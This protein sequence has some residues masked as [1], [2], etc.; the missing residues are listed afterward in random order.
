MNTGKVRASNFELLRIFSMF[1]IVLNHLCQHGIWFR[2]DAEIT[3]NLCISNCLL[4]WTGTLGNWLFVLT[5]GYFVSKSEFSWKKV[6]KLW[7]Q[8]FFYSVIIGVILYLSQT[9]LIG[10]YNEDYIELGF[11]EA[12]KPA[13]LIDLAQSFAPTLFGN[14]WFASSY[15]LFYCFTPFLNESLKVLDEKKHKHLVIL[16]AFAGTVIYM[17]YGQRLFDEGNLFYFILGYYVAS[18]IRIYDPKFLKNNKINVIGC[19]TLS[20]C[21]I[22]WILMVLY[23]RDKVPFIANH[24]VQ[25][26]SYPFAMTR[27]PSLLNAIFVFS[28]FHNLKIEN[29]KFI[30]TLAGTTFGIYLIHENQLLNKVIWHKLFQ[31][32]LFLDSKFLFAY[33]IFAIVIVF[34]VCAGIDWLRQRYVEKPLMNLIFSKKQK[35]IKA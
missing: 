18:Y 27:F 25:F 26:F 30:N 12:A 14:N 16:M 7:S 1:L 31:F 15:L 10:F 4:G 23:Y 29:N 5:S 19:V 21:F 9:P 28:I 3:T 2:L 33:M 24:Y 32:D 35:E 20:T 8:V 6:F 11:F 34:L 13:T 22:L 17:I